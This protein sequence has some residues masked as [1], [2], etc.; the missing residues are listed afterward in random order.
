MYTAEPMSPDQK[1]NYLIWC[2]ASW[3]VNCRGDGS[4][5]T[6]HLTQIA[7][8]QPDSNRLTDDRSTTFDWRCDRRIITPIRDASARIDIAQ[9]PSQP[10]LRDE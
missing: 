2:G 8:I 4:V 3:W 9:S 10:G 1:R 5:L 7:V 6:L